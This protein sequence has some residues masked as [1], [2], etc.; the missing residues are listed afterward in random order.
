M[1]D[2]HNPRELK[3]SVYLR[4]FS[5]ATRII[6]M[7]TMFAS[8]ILF[9]AAM[10]MRSESDRIGFSI[11][12][13]ALLLFATLVWATGVFHGAV[14]SALPTLASLDFKLERTLRLLAAQKEPRMFSHS[15]ETLPAGPETD[16]DPAPESLPEVKAPPPPKPEP[17]PV[18]KVPC[19]SCGGLIHPEASRCVHCM[20][21]IKLPKAS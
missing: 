3:F 16:P 18:E 1:S 20:K 11:M 14:S 8:F 2:D 5:R 12:S 4:R 19:P 15:A 17:P 7:L 21:R 13:F 6:G 9:A 10:D